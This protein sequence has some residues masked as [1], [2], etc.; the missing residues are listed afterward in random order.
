MIRSFLDKLPNNLNLKIRKF[1]YEIGPYKASNSK[2]LLSNFSKTSNDL[3]SIILPNYNHGDFL[4]SAIQ[5]V[6]TQDYINLELIV[7]DD[8]STDH[9]IEI[10][11]K[12]ADRPKFRVIFSK[13]L[14]ISSALNI[15]FANAKGS[16]LSWTSA[17]NL[18]S[19]NAVSFLVKAL[20]DNPECGM[21]HSDYQIIDENS[22]VISNSNFRRYDQDK[23]NSS[24]IR[25]SRTKQLEYYLPDNYIGPFFLYRREV[26][27]CVGDYRVLLGFED[28]DYWIRIS[29]ISTIL[30]IPSDG[31]LYSYRLHPNTLTAST[32][33]N[34]TYRNLIKYLRSVDY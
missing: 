17:D 6:L 9:S 23:Y 4:E 8:G 1:F 16:F 12:Y 22:E 18:M 10:L 7:V 2:N 28:Y 5:S 26:Y 34:R 25:T 24:I 33:E 14:G 11:N 21:V 19:S 30:H 20:R 27:D 15:G 3:V 13:H 32:R 31:S 29:R